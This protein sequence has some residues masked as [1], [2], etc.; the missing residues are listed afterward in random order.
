VVEDHLEEL[1][2]LEVR[3]AGHTIG[4]ARWEAGNVRDVL[5]YYAAAPERL[6]GRQSPGARRH[7]DVTFHEPLGVVGVIVPW[8]FPMPIAGWGFAPALAAGNTGCSNR[9]SSLSHRGPDRRARA[10]GRSCPSTS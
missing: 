1:A 6:F 8:N 7:R 4:N 9:R 3:N 10:R 2:E 5:D